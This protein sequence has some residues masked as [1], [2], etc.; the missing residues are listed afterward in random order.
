MKIPSAMECFRGD[1]LESAHRTRVTADAIWA[2]GEA[3]PTGVMTQPATW[4][5]H[6]WTVQRRRFRRKPWESAS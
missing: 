4:Y 2:F 6:R 1:L 3:F 5:R